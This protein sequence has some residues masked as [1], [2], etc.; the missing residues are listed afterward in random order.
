MGM[1]PIA[2]AVVV[3]ASICG[4][5]PQVLAIEVQ[6]DGIGFDPAV[7]ATGSGH[8][9][10]VGLRERARLAGGAVEVTST[11]GTGT[12]LRLCVPRDTGGRP[13]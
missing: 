9:G 6:D 4:G 7:L 10:L 12:T 11:R 5:A 3:V 1:A 8:Y 2:L 13:P